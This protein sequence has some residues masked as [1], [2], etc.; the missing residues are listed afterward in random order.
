MKIFNKTK[1][2]GKIMK[3]AEYIKL[4]ENNINTL[5]RAYG[6]EKFQINQLG[7]YSYGVYRKNPNS[8]GIDRVSNFHYGKHSSKVDLKIILNQ[9]ELLI[10]GLALGVEL[11]TNRISE[12]IA[13]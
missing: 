13:A 1:K 5:N 12:S 8:S 6:F 7:L 10:E 4:I 2:K 3:V 11:S 9:I